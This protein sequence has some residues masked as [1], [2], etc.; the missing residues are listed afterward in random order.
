MDSLQ[1][2]NILAW[3]GRF[4]NAV[5]NVSR[6]ILGAARQRLAASAWTWDQG[7]LLIP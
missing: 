3:S 2:Y 5:A 4:M 7:K 6:A 1:K